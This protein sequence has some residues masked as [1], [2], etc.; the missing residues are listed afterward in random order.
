MTALTLRTRD[1]YVAS[2][3]C[4][5]LPSPP[6]ADGCG[7]ARSSLSLFEDALLYLEL[8]V[9]TEELPLL[10]RMFADYLC[11][12]EA[13]IVEFVSFGALMVRVASP[14]CAP[15]ASCDEE[16][17][18]IRAQ[19]EAI[20]RTKR[21][22]HSDETLIPVSK[23]IRAF[24]SYLARRLVVLSVEQLQAHVTAW[25]ECDDDATIQR[26]LRAS[27]YRVC[28]MPVERSDARN[29]RTPSGVSY[30]RVK[31]PAMPPA[32]TQ[33]LS[34][35]R[36]ALQPST[37]SRAGSL[38][39][40]VKRQR[41]LLETNGVCPSQRS[42]SEES[43][44]D[45]MYG[46]EGSV[47]TEDDEAKQHGRRRGRVLSV[48]VCALRSRLAEHLKQYEARQPWKSVFHP[49]LPLPFVEDDAPDLARRLPRS[50]MLVML[51][52]NTMDAPLRSARPP[53]PP[54]DPLGAERIHK[55]ALILDLDPTSAM[56]K[57]KDDKKELT[58]HAD[59]EAKPTVL[60]PQSE[61]QRSCNDVLFA[62]LF[63][64]VFFF[65][66]AIAVVYGKE[67][68]QAPETQDDL[69]IAKDTIK[70]AHAK[71]KYALRISGAIAGGALV[72]SL[73]WTVIML[74]CGKMLIWMSVISI[75]VI[76]VGAGV[77]SSKFL[78]DE[79]KNNAFYWWPVAVSSLFSALVLLYVCC[80]RRRIAFASAN[81]QVACKAVL[82][83]PVIMFTAILF[84]MLQIVWALVWC[85][86]TY[87]AVNH[88]DKINR[89]EEKPSAGKKFGILVGM[90]VIFFW[91]TFVCRNIVMVSTAGTVS[92]WWHYSTQDRRPLTTTRALARALTLSFGSICFGSLI[93]SIIQTIRVILRSWQKALQNQGNAVAACLLGCVGCIVGCIQSW[94]EYF[95]RFAY[96]Y[97]GIYGYSFIASGKR[98]WQLFASKGWSAIA[99]DSLIVNVLLFGKIV[100]GF[101]GA[102][103]GWG[104]VSYGKP[105]WTSN[106]ENAEVVLGLSG[107]LIG[108]SVADVIMTVVDGAVATVFILFAEDPHSLASSHASSHESLHKTWKEIYPTE[109]ESVTKR[110]DDSV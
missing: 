60:P 75:C 7:L 4:G 108:Y 3:S 12:R 107:F 50:V 78:H 83:Y 72:M 103:A 37:T 79:D 71:Y 65:T 84:T 73:V 62:A 41:R 85:V 23:A 90:L 25:F 13:T 32:P 40:T 56:A 89:T 94:V 43:L 22:A 1:G 99:N 53:D 106:V 35:P 45:D 87:A 92:S 80:I 81:L 110:Q 93:V 74:I 96:A 48:D 17:G 109:Y 29:E 6:L 54:V 36:R 27:E 76:S 38:E 10:T 77:M 57:K 9:E 44:W 30:E 61:P 102:A 58:K 24:F 69:D 16:D 105:E 49:G 15:L 34:T 42:D 5:L 82:S 11:A 88:P 39:P 70:Q 26:L 52:S 68:L 101:V 95:N 104:T 86:A 100:V 66:V 55:S 33:L 46:D 14:V 8:S 63:L 51:A 31:L 2:G 59:A 19:R 67:V 20:L 18:A 21:L 91:G 98:A 64:L 28:F 97:V 47:Q